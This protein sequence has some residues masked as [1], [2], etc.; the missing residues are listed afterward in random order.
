[1]LVAPVQSG[2]R[3]ALKS[4]QQLQNSDLLTKEIDRYPG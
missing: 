2:N 3:P 4:G 1:M